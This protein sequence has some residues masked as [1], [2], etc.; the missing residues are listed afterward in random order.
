MKSVTIFTDGSCWPN[1]GP[2]GW[3][4]ILDCEGVRKEIS[5]S[6]RETTTNNRMELLAALKALESLKEACSVDLYTDSQYLQKGASLWLGRWQQKN[7]KGVIN[8]DLW[9]RVWRMVFTHPIRWHWV[10]GHDGHAENE[11]CDALAEKARANL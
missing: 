11:R 6:V 3:A 1:P 4:A 7:W 5:G 10:R 2:G 9:R 8:A